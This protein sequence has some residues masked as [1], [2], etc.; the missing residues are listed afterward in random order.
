MR[1]A[2]LTAILLQVFGGT[3]SAKPLVLWHAYRAGERAALEETVR[4]WNAGARRQ[5]PPIELLAVPYDAFPDKIGAAI[6]RGHG[7]D[8]FI[9]AHDRVGDW[10]ESRIVEPLDFW[11]TEAHADQFLF[12]A[13]D[14][15]CYGDSLYGLPLAFKSTALYYNRTLVPVPPRTTDELLALGRRL[16]DR[17]AGRFGLVYDNTKLYFHAPWLTGFGGTLFDAK[18]SL[19][20]ATASAVA[21]VVFAR[22]L[23]GPSGI[24]PPEPS[25]TLATSLFASG[26]AAMAI[27]GPW[28]LGELPAQLDFAVVPLPTVSSSRRRAAPFVG[29]EGLMLSARSGQ[30]DAAFAAMTFLTSAPM[31]LIRALKARQPVATAAAW[32]DPRIARDAVLTAFREQLQ[33]AVVMP[34]TP[35]M[36]LVWSPYDSAL[37]KAVGLGADPLSALKEAEAE[38]RRYLA[39]RAKPAPSVQR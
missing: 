32:R 36:R 29:A 24:V 5:H 23:G 33:Y 2:I 27:S 9:F 17:S 1:A 38:I 11:M 28:M 26:K 30:K 31:A 21:A 12:K 37:Q 10:A 4:H 34:G 22:R 15:L 20:V 39:S 6:P 25:A 13:L 19:Q 3:A 14:A 18:G 16:T 7:P 35:E 8:L